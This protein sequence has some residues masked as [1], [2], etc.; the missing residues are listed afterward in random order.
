MSAGPGGAVRDRERERGEAV[1]AAG[2]G[3]R[4]ARDLAALLLAAPAQ[5]PRSHWLRTGGLPCVT[6]PPP[7]TPPHPP[8]TRRAAPP[9]LL[10][11]GGAAPPPPLPQLGC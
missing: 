3:V 5:P 6:V 4:R 10:P 11:P 2:R 9:P 7:P 8:R 1:A